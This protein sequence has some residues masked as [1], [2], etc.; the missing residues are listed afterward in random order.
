[1]TDEQQPTADNDDK[2]TVLIVD[3]EP[4]NLRVLSLVLQAEYRV[5]AARSGQEALNAIQTQPKPDVVLMDIMMPE[6]DGYA[7]LRKM[8]EINPDIPVIFVTAL[9]GELD[10]QRG[11]QMGAADYITKPFRPA[12]VRARIKIQLK[13]KAT[14]EDLNRQVRKRTEELR[15]ANN[16]LRQSLIETVRSFS[17]MLEN[18]DPALAGHS[19]RVAEAARRLATKMGVPE[20][21]RNDIVFA[22]LLSRV[23]TITLPQKI[24]DKPLMGLSKPERD[25]LMISIIRTR[26]I[27]SRIGPL[28]HAAEI[29]AAQFERWDGS[30]FPRRLAGTDIPLGA[31]ILS[32]CRDFDLFLEGMLDFKTHLVPD[33][34][35]NLRRK[36]G[37]YYD[38]E[39]VEIYNDQIG[40]MRKVARPLFD[41]GLADVVEGQELAEVRFGDEIFVRDTLATKGLMREL[42]DVMRETGLYCSIKI[43]ARF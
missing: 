33:A 5:R 30:G 1:M 29:I 18:R 28:S 42:E 2:P 15:Q 9:D 19:K 37:L 7:T 10:E 26:Q 38:P 12:I 39:I 14:Q 6:M 22:G 31:R 43:R 36:S 34:K 35:A 32:V 11:L 40:R 4:A 24:L 20:R 41:V 27:F 25:E 13:L 17:I 8:R 16:S 23:G 21:E 3:D